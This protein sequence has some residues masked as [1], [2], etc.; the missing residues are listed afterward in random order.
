[1]IVACCSG[2]PAELMRY[3]WWEQ[4]MRLAAQGGARDAPLRTVTMAEDGKLFPQ[5]RSGWTTRG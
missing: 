1:M 3:T 4:A 5:V 2:A